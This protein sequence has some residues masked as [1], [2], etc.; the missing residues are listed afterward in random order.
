MRSIVILFVGF[1]A[2]VFYVPDSVKT[3]EQIAIEKT[4]AKQKAQEKAKK[5][6]AKRLAKIEADRIYNLPE[7][8]KK[9]AKARAISVAETTASAD[10]RTRIK[11]MALIPSS[12]DFYDFIGTSSRTYENFSPEKHRIIIRRDGDMKNA[13]GAEIKFKGVC[14]YDYF[15]KTNTISLVE[16]LI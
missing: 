9:R 11:S 4:I 15:H 5:A 2:L 16:V 3:D 6:E 13:F 7:N 10:C 14:K 8:V 1:V 12:V